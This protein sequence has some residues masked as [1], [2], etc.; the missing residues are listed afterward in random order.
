LRQGGT[1]RS[2]RLE[3]AL[4]AVSG[5]A[6]FDDGSRHRGLQEMRQARTDLGA[7]SLAGAQAAAPAVLEHRAALELGRP[8]LACSVAD[9]LAEHSGAGAMC[10]SCARGRP[11]RRA[12]TRPHAL[13]S[14]H[15]STVGH[16]RAAPHDCRG[17]PRGDHRAG[18][19]EV[20]GARRALRT[21]LSRSWVTTW[22]A[23]GRPTRALA[24]GR[25]AHRRRPA[26]RWPPPSSADCSAD[27]GPARA[28]PQSTNQTSARSSA[29]RP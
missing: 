12:A 25:S 26:P 5:A 3:F 23:G 21:A 29:A 19:G 14:A 4:R 2:P 28:R 6:L 20:H 22:L 15:C 17:P 24:A 1:P 10:C 27:G 8:D 13:P 16:R 18:D 11:C 7:V 9:W